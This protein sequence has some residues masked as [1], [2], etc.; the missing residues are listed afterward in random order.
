[1]IGVEENEYNQT[2]LGPSVMI[3]NVA[4]P[5]EEAKKLAV[6]EVVKE[7]SIGRQTCLRTS[8]RVTA[9]VDRED[10]QG[11]NLEETREGFPVASPLYRLGS[12]LHGMTTFFTTGELITTR[13]NLVGHLSSAILT[14]HG[15]RHA[16]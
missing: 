16:K 7:E 9:E 8:L 3:P 6:V 15:S 11:A 4:H 10:V 2:A 5:E 12:G 13:R 14:L 1:M